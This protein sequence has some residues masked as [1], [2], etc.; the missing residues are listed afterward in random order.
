M[1]KV[2]AVC[3]TL[4]AVLLLLAAAGISLGS[5]VDTWAVPVLWLV[6]GVTK[7]MRNFSK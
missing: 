7:L 2:S 1:A 5:L 6:V 4:I 3:I